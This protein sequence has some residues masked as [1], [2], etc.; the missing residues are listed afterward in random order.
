MPTLPVELTV[1]PWG[2]VPGAVMA[3]VYGAVPPVAVITGVSA[4]L[5]VPK[6]AVYGLAL[7]VV[8]NRPPA[9]VRLNVTEPVT[10]ITAASVAVNVTVYSPAVFAA[11]VPAMAPVAAVSVRPAGSTPE[12]IA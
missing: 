11:G 9:I 10:G 2:S 5:A 4:A 8:M 7:A 1:I 3:N 6:V 12:V